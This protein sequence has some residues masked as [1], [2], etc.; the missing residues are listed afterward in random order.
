MTIKVFGSETCEFCA[1][2]KEKLDVMGLAYDALNVA[3]YTDLHDG[4]RDDDAIDVLVAL[5]LNDRRLPLIKIDDAFFDYV[6]AM[7]HLGLR[8]TPVK[9]VGGSCTFR[10]GTQT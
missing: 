3:D 10:K 2:A 5:E 4:W 8:T 9:C 6:G 7:D 1:E